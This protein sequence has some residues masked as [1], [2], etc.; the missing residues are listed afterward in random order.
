[1]RLADEI[2]HYVLRTYIEPAR[3][4]GDKVVK[5]RAG[6]VNDRMG[7]VSRQPAVAGALGADKFQDFA[8]VRLISREGPHQGAN[9]VFTFEIL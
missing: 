6:D 9:L 4:R 1:M 7:L 3:L 8:R 2:R 5:I